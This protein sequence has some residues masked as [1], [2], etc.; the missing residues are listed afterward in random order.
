MTRISLAMIVRDDEATLEECLKSVRDHV[1][2]ICICDTGSTDRSPEIAK[3][4]ADK[5]QLYLGCNDSDG[6][7]IDFADARNRSFEMVSG[8]WCLWLDGDDI[9]RGAENIRSLCEQGDGDYFTWL[10]P[11]EYAR[12]EHGNVTTLQ[13][14]ER[15]MKPP[16]A[17][18]WRSP[19]H[20]YAALTDEPSVGSTVVNR[21]TDRVVVEHRSNVAAAAGKVR[22]PGRNLR[23]LEKYVARVGN[24]DPRALYYLGI[25][26]ASAGRV[27]QAIR[28]LRE[29]ANRSEWDD[30]QCKALL[31]IGEFYRN[32][33]GDHEHAN[34]WS[35]KAMTTKSWP[36]PYFHIGRSYY[37]MAQR[38]EDPRKNYTRAAFFI[39]RG[40]EL[41]TD[42]VLF[43]NPQERHFIHAILNVCLH[44]VG[45]NDDALWSCEEGL[46][47]CP[48]ELKAAIEAEPEKYEQHPFAIMLNNRRE[49]MK[50]G[51]LAQV[52]TTVGEL[53]E[54]GGLTEQQVALIRA[55]LDGQLRIE[56]EAGRAPKGLPGPANGTQGEPA[57]GGSAPSPLNE[58]KPNPGKLDLVMFL[59]PA[60]ERWTPVT[61]A[62][63]GMGGSETMAWELA[64]RLRKLGHR[65]RF[66]ADCAPNQEGQYEGVEWLQWQRFRDVHCDVLI[67]SRTPWAV[68]DAVTVNFGGQVATIGGCKATVQLL[69]CHDI[70]A[71]PEL[72]ANRLQRTDYILCLSQWHKQ[73]F[74]ERYCVYPGGPSVIAEEK[75]IVTRNGIDLT[76]FEGT[77]ERNPHRAVYSSSPDRGLLAAVLAWPKVRAKVPDAELHCYYGWENWEWTAKLNND[78][79]QLSQIAH[80]KQQCEATEGVVMHG[81]IG[82]KELAREFMRSGVWCYPTWFAETSCI[83]AME[84]QAAGCYIVT[85]PIA[86]LNETVGNIHG[87]MLETTWDY[88]N[89]PTQEFIDEVAEKTVKWMTGEFLNIDRAG[90][91]RRHFGLDELA[92]DWSAMLE[93]LHA[94]LTDNPMPKFGGAGKAAE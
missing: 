68:D 19:V 12:D 31:Q 47:G 5:F 63:K 24:G 10:V 34:Q 74:R 52:K 1:D 16:H 91:A 87:D 4:Y 9:C 66:Y 56:T 3:R 21:A 54:I 88:P 41:P 69:W 86:A 80:L 78:Q 79:A 8:E 85:S 84:A 76:R 46:K 65:V 42:V 11:Y 94:E 22:E 60:L 43:A 45:R 33:L 59:G 92:A 82:Q 20:E 53:R 25:E 2:E 32:I 61:W 37:A 83:T 40:L 51:K 39:K 17:Y 15:L 44:A 62:E 7:I 67:A 71:G 6:R 26:Y 57:A 89:P 36:E 55:V 64:R 29:Y 73:F 50:H 49:Y 81:R 70:H 48:P 77:E 90:Y 72:D 13:M 18:T 30:E 28:Y 93:R 35:L 58:T 27:D 14:R 75:V 23:I 38:G